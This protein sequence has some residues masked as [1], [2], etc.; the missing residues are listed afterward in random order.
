MLYF[1]PDKFD[2][3]KIYEAIK[4]F[5][6]IGIV[7]D[8]GKLYFSY[9]GLK[10]LEDIMVDNI[11]EVKHFVERWGSFTKEIENEI[12]KEIIYT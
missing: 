8:E 12:G 2:F 4:H 9:P 1:N 7:K 3:W 11:H 6:P 5:Y 10:E